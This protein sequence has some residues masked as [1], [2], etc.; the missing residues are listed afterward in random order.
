MDKNR[1]YDLIC[2][3]SIS[4][5]KFIQID[6]EDKPRNYKVSDDAKNL[7]LKLLE[8]DSGTRLGRKGLDEIKKHQFFSGINFEDLEK[9]K[10]K[11]P[12]KP[13][14]PKE[15]EDITTNFDEKY[16]NMEL[17][18]SPTSDWAQSKEFINIFEDFNNE[19][20]EVGDDDDFEIIEHPKVDK[21]V[22]E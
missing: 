13:G 14:E 9:K 2:S 16:L 6:N 5:P 15:N 20:E 8:K 1:I 22:D 7:I 18:E 19:I 11:T 12:F 4:F 10:I 17:S 21:N 3:G